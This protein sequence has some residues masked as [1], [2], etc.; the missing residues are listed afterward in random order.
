MR[1]LVVGT[2]QVDSAA[3]NCELALSSMGHD[4]ELFD[5][6]KYP[7]VLQP[8]RRSWRS[9]LYVNFALTRAGL[10]D[11][12]FQRNLLETAERFSPEVVLVIPLFSVETGTVERLRR[13]GAKVAGWF[14][15]HVA[16]LGS[17][18]F[19]LADYD[20]LFFKD[21][22][23]VD[24]FRDGAGLRHVHYLPEACEP[25]RHHPLPLSEAD[26]G[27]FGCD[28]MVYGNLYAYRARLLDHL[29]DFD[30]RFYGA[31]PARW[32]KQPVAERWQGFPIFNDEKIRAVLAAK[33]VV[34]SCHY[35]EVQ[36]ANARIFEVA[37]I[38]GFQV[39]DAPAVGEFFEPGV[40]IATFRGPTELR[41]V[42]RHYLSRPEERSAMAIRAQ[43]RAH[44]EH[45]YARRL[46]TLLATIGAPHDG[47]RRPAEA[48]ASRR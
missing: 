29:L 46:E 4:V 40:E 28:L 5:P 18:Q 33:I 48:S 31:K 26:R 19:L 3:M 24:R 11:R 30:M 20:G 32:M 35:A 45:T 23:I 27:R 12:M 8:L 44:R 1:I 47:P 14:Q 16:N 6:D 15:D 9:K 41:D 22:Y 39:A 17:H 37:G 42:I 25:S 43:Q 21:R 13:G 34:N 7:A 38:G 36:S 2:G 10:Y